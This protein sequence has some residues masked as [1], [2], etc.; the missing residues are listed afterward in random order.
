ML[1]FPIKRSYTPERFSQHSC[2]SRRKA[3][4]EVAHNVHSLADDSRMAISLFYRSVSGTHVPTRK[5]QR[6]HIPSIFLDT[7]N[8]KLYNNEKRHCMYWWNKSIVR[9]TI[10]RVSLLPTSSQYLYLYLYLYIS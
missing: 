7:A 1:F 10:H 9:S 6:R 4:N 3:K 5:T 8:A 2:A